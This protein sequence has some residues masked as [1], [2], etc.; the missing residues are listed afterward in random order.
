[1]VKRRIGFIQPKEEENKAEIA[2]KG[3]DKEFQRLISNLEMEE[4]ISLNELSLEK[5]IKKE[6]VR[7]HKWI[8]KLQKKI[9]KRNVLMAKCEG[10]IT[11]FPKK[12]L[13]LLDEIGKLDYEIMP[14]VQEIFKELNKHTLPE[15]AEL[16][17]EMEL[18]ISQI[19][20][21]RS[22]ASTLGSTLNNLV[23]PINQAVQNQYLEMLKRDLLLNNPTLR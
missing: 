8:L 22:I 13:E 12:S 5:K 14:E 19:R 6:L 17:K 2:I 11:N 15:V 10:Y 3:I 20:H 18:S 9:E 7:L 16:Y 1:M 4:N 21:I 23:R